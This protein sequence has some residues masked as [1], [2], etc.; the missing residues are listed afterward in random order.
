MTTENGSQYCQLKEIYQ[1]KIK[2]DDKLW[3]KFHI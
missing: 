1:M 2:I 3:E